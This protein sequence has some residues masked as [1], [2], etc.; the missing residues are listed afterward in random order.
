MDKEVDCFIMVPARLAKDTSMPQTHKLVLAL[1]YTLSRNEKRTDLNPSGVFYGT[2][3][4]IGYQLG[5]IS[6]R[7]ISGI[8]TEHRRRGNI[9]YHEETDMYGTKR[10]LWL[11]PK[12]YASK[13]E[14]GIDDFT[15]PKALSDQELNDMHD[16]G[17]EIDQVDF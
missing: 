2:N 1:I 9:E 10:F 4:Y 14:A 17:K 15:S 12:V 3:A 16:K 5:G 7:T 8:I 11:S 13:G 6:N